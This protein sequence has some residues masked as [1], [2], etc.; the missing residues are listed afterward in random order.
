MKLFNKIRN[1]LSLKQIQT[2]WT[3]FTYKCEFRITLKVQR[4][5][6]KIYIYCI[7]LSFFHAAFKLCFQVLESL[8]EL[9][10]R[11]EGQSNH[12]NRTKTLSVLCFLII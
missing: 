5:S 2:V 9:Q 1:C 8:R 6:E 10:S 3:A 7:Y 12:S 4:L 11:Q